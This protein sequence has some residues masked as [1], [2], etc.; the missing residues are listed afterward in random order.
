MIYGCQGTKED[1]DGGGRGGHEKE[2]LWKNYKMFLYWLLR[3]IG[4]KPQN[5]A[6]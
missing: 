1:E 6:H 3:D 4:G 2:Q 5:S